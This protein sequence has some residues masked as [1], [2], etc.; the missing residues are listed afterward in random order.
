MAS[1]K[2]CKSKVKKNASSAIF[3]LTAETDEADDDEWRLEPPS[4]PIPANTT[5]EHTPLGRDDVHAFDDVLSMAIPR[6]TGRPLVEGAKRHTFRAHQA[7]RGAP[8]VYADDALTTQPVT[9]GDL[10]LALV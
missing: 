7:V 10:A 4:S 6:M 1:C 8:V 3:V 2:A 5:T 9:D